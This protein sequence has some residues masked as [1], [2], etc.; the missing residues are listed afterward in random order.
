[1][2]V[3]WLETSQLALANAT[4]WPSSWIP[5]ARG[6]VTN[7]SDLASAQQV[8][9]DLVTSTFYLLRGIIRNDRSVNQPSLLSSGYQTLD[10]PNPST[11]LSPTPVSCWSVTHLSFD[12]T[13][14]SLS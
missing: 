13:D 1:M 3:A 9:S 10:S 12:V 14:H 7:E 5:S 4:V 11:T 2:Y 8:S 6:R